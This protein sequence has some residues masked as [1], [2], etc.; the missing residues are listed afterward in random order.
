[1]QKS[2]S[3]DWFWNVNQTNTD[4][5]C[6]QGDTSFQSYNN[7]TLC[8]ANNTFTG[9]HR[10]YIDD[11]ICTGETDIFKNDYIGRVVISTGKVK[12]DFTR[13]IEDKQEWYS[14]IDKDGI[15]IE[16]AVPVVRLSRKK[17][18]K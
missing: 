17:R 10:C 1:M 12:T 4:Y 3:G 7:K 16:D 8:I 13:K 2:F 6:V 9:F 18:D 14:E 11:V 15:S 5:V